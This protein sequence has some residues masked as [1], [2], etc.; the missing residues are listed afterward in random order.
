MNIYIKK[1][2]IIHK[3]VSEL[4]K[5]DQEFLSSVNLLIIIITVF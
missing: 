4:K 5:L 1:I 2:Y 3:N